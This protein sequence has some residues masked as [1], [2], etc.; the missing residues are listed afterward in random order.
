MSFRY[1]K[2]KVTVFLLLFFSVVQYSCKKYLEAKPDKSL[3]TPKTVTEL[4][5][6]LDFEENNTGFPSGSL[7]SDDNLYFTY[8]AW[9]S[10]LYP[11]ER[12]SYIWDGETDFTR[13]WAPAYQR[14]FTSNVVLDEVKKIKDATASEQAY[15]IVEGS[16]LFYR[17]IN[18]Y[19][20]AQIFA[21]PYSI[22]ASPSAFG[23][24]L[25]ASPNIDEVSVRSTVQQTFDKIINDLK[26]SVHLLP[27]S[28]AYKTRPSKTAAYA[29]LAR[30]YLV[31]NDYTNAGKYADS[32]LQT[33]SSLLD[34][35]DITE[36]DPNSAHPFKRFNK[37]VI[38]HIVSN[39]V[40]DLYN[41]KVDSVLY[42]S[43]DS[44]DI[45]KTAFFKDNGNGT[46]QFKGNYAETDII[47]LFCGLSTNEI[48]LIRAECN[49]RAGMP[50]EAMADLNTLLN[51]RWKAGTFIPLDAATADEAL[52]KIV[53]ERRKELCFRSSLRWSDLRRL[54]QD[55]RYSKTLKRVFGTEIYELQAND[56]RYTFLIPQKIID[57]SGMQQ[58]PR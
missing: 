10:M 40:F 42:N 12:L 7:L 25:K 32:C 46:F 28:V 19:E 29:L 23:I 51:K 22:E 13:D 9:N 35:N 2:S 5:Q 39:F 14:I 36:A 27:A 50:N 38:F 11:D 55:N 53:K 48:Y 33:D 30:T 41:S 37:E 44:N 18:F 47:A 57:I 3:T 52:D 45:R 54:N 1:I 56:K 20:L 21:L 16:A 6:L 24:P 26:A 34:Y 43:Y 17:A 49:A 58:N 31:M 8:D 15:N 4:Q